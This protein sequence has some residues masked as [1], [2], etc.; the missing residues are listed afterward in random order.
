MSLEEITDALEILSVNFAK[1]THLVQKFTENEMKKADAQPLTTIP[2]YKII[3][4][5][6]GG[7]GKTS[8]IRRHLTGQFEEKYIATL[9]VEVHPLRFETNYGQIC[10]NIWDCA[11]QEKFGGL[12]DGYY[13]QA[14]A[15]IVMYDVSQPETFKNIDNWIVNIRRVCPDIPIVVVG[16]KVDACGFGGLRELVWDKQIQ[17]YYVS[18][19]SNYN[20]AEPF[21]YLAQV[22]MARNDLQLK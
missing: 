20:Y 21:K 2:T 1:L 3:I 5:G 18:S 12:R 7:V 9:G 19:K 11:G 15:A 4:V 14:H 6:D 8:L 13:I 22:L 10:F 17:H 16:N